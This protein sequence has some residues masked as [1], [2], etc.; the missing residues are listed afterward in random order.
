MLRITVHD[1][2]PVLTFQLEGALKGHLVPELEKCWESAMTSK[3]ERILRVD[4]TGVVLIDEAGKDCLAVLHDQGAEFIA[5]DCLM[6][7]I[8]DEIAQSRGSRE[9]ARSKNRPR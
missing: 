5:A 3:P 7:A 4:L 2:P 9:L 6:N 8:V 1:R